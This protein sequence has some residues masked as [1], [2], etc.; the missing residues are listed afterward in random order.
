MDPLSIAS[1]SGSV[2]L[3]CI[4]LSKQIYTWVNQTKDVDEE[5]ESFATEVVAYSRVLSAIDQNL[6]RP[7]I[8]EAVRTR[9]GDFWS[10]VKRSLDDCS[11]TLA[12][13]EKVLSKLGGASNNPF[14]KVAKNVKLGVAYEK[15]TTLRRQISTYNS[16]MQLALQ[17][18][19]VS[20]NMNN[21]ALHETLAS[22]IN[23][24]L[25]ETRVI[26]NKLEPGP[27]EAN[28]PQRDSA[29]SIESPSSDP[30]NPAED[31]ELDINFEAKVYDHITEVLETAKSLTSV[32]IQSDTVSVTGSVVSMS[33]A[34]YAA[35]ERWIWSQ[36]GPSMLGWAK[37]EMK[38]PVKSGRLGVYDKRKGY[39][40]DNLHFLCNEIDALCETEITRPA[41]VSLLRSFFW[42]WDRTILLGKNEALFDDAMGAIKQQQH[43]G[44]ITAVSKN[45]GSL[46]HI[47]A[48]LNKVEFIGILLQ[49]GA[50][51]DVGS[52]ELGTPLHFAALSGGTEAVLF[53][54][55]QGANA[56]AMDS[57]M[58]TPFMKAC[59]VGKETTAQILVN[60]TTDV[61]LQAQDT[62]RTALHSSILMGIDETSKLIIAAAL[63]VD[64]P[65]ANGVTALIMACDVQLFAN[66]PV[67]Q[68]LLDRGANI[69][70]METTGET[71]LALACKGGR[72]WVV[73]ELLQ[74]GASLDQEQ[75]RFDQ[76][77]IYYACHRGYAEILKLLM[78]HGAT[79]NSS[80]R[81]VEN[82]LF[83]AAVGSGSE[84]VTKLL[85][86][87]DPAH[88]LFAKT[89][90]RESALHIACKMGLS[91]VIVQWLVDA[92]AENDGVDIDERSALHHAVLAGNYELVHILLN[93]N[94]AIS[95]RDNLGRTALDLAIELNNTTAIVYFID[96][97]VML[98]M[99]GN[100]TLHFASAI[101]NVKSL[102]R[103]FT[104]NKTTFSYRGVT[105][106]DLNKIG[107]SALHIATEKRLLQNMSFLLDNGADVNIVDSISGDTPLHLAAAKHWKEGIDLL[108]ERGADREIANARGLLP[109]DSYGK[110]IAQLEPTAGSRISR[111]F[112]SVSQKFRLG[113]GKGSHATG[114]GKPDGTDKVKRNSKMESAV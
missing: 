3:V 35:I 19:L 83:V 100:S 50:E 43:G 64:V 31:D 56:D 80:K 110:K 61:M 112:G 23:C 68:L 7:A 6:R 74:R 86:E 46:L 102:K 95:T 39:Q 14:A 33:D 72:T 93:A 75:Q 47:V 98:D 30:D 10:H 113:F 21:E 89:S 99:K 58:M 44:G 49:R 8:A 38:I 9:E 2:A 104:L 57:Q 92:G 20:Q 53:L 48:L 106:N 94:V 18:C 36:E 69:N 37:I 71:A 28:S 65:D 101:D 16:T 12:L 15:I 84:A 40:V 78:D 60:R 41:A 88:F 105:V 97:L 91:S 32:V 67:I 4:R 85:M 34:T 77:P 26:R 109:R 27:V 29:I 42:R 1:A 96:K 59:E 24:I 111:R 17:M 90:R 82:Q 103:R 11:E 66:E 107:D 25:D 70:A 79:I 22:K 5:V 73:R 55:D 114:S 45:K 51:I 81:P 108:L 76:T 13:L 52:G 62:L 54:L 87:S 63:N